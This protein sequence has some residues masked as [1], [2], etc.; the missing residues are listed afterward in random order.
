M[1]S[2]DL[3]LLSLFPATREQTLESRKR[4]SVQWGRGLTLQQYLLRED[5]LDVA[6]HAQDG[7]FTT[8][9]LALRN[10]PTTLD[11]R[12]SCET[13][14]RKSLIKRQGSDTPEEAFGYGI[15]SVFTPEKNRGKGYAR[16][17]MNLL[18]WVVAPHSTL[19][20]FP[21]S[22]GGA[23]PERSG[24]N[25]AQF[26]VLYSDIGPSYYASTGPSEDSEGWIVRGPYSTISV[27]TEGANNFKSLESDALVKWLTEKD[28]EDILDHDADLMRASFPSDSKPVSFTFLPNEGVA[29]FLVRRTLFFSPGQPYANMVPDKWG[30]QLLVEGQLHFATWTFDVR[31]PPATLIATR[32]RSTKVTFPR[33]LSCMLLAAQENNMRRVEFWSL[34]KELEEIAKELG[35]KTEERDEH[36]NA[37]KWYGPEKNE[38]IY[39]AHNEKFAWC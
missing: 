24:C 25:N 37:F 34:P 15:A 36:L 2:E 3:S 13:Y 19:P 31:P 29:L 18:H 1:P 32:I 12:C 33:I 8:W 26:S 21:S 7:K 11:F 27:V 17:M 22:W 20:P 4:T 14:R 23:P 39:W 28:C 35:G 30:V 10:D 38:D 9:V 6:E 16:R 5:Q